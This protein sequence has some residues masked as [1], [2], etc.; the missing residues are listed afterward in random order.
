MIS[1]DAIIIGAGISGLMAAIE[2]K[3]NG[4]EHVLVLDRDIEVGGALNKCVHGGFHYKSI[5]ENLTTTELINELLEDALNL[6]VEIRCNTSVI[7]V[8]KDKLV[9]IVNEALGVT[10]I[11]AKSIIL[12]TGCRERPLGYKNILGHRVAGIVTAFSALN[13]IN[14][15]GVLPGKNCIILGSGDTAAVVARTLALEGAKVKAIIESSSNI[16]AINSMSKEHIED[17]SIPVLLKHR[18]IKIYGDA[19]VQGVDIIKIDKDNEIIEGTKQHIKCDTLVLS[20]HLNP[21]YILAQKLGIELNKDNRGIIVSDKMET[22]QSGIFA[23]GTV[24][25]GYTTADKVMKEGELAGRMCSEY[26]KGLSLND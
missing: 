22:S 20:V 19:R 11:K 10:I 4:I 7:E 25:R 9:T 26:I 6:G 16:R 24:L 8:S 12:A 18:V 13:Y 5:K 14:R 23:A 15:K 1:Y 3:K 17:F 21:E 2:M